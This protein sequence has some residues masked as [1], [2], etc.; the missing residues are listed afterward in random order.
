MAASGASPF[1]PS[2][3][4]RRPSSVANPGGEIL[5]YVKAVPQNHRTAA[6]ATA[7]GVE[8]S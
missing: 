4:L 7:P 2:R 8:I 5:I 1:D 3:P 6:T